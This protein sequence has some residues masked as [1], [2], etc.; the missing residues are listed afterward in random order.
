[1]DVDGINVADQR[2]DE[3]EVEF[4]LGALPS[5]WHNTQNVL[6]DLGYQR[7]AGND[8]NEDTDEQRGLRR[9]RTD[10]DEDH[11]QESNHTDNSRHSDLDEEKVCRMCLSS[12]A[13]LG[14]DGMSLGR[15]ISPCHCDG[16]MR[17]VHD[18]CLDQW[19][20]K[21]AA[22]EAARVCGQ[23]HA[24]YRFKRTPYSSLS[25]FVQ[26]SQMLRI[27][28]CVLVVFIASFVFGVL[29]FVSLRA[30]A[31][32]KDTP[33]AFIRDAALRPVSLEKLSWNIT[34]RQDEAVADVWMPADLVRRNRGSLAPLSVVDQ[35]L[36]EK[37][38]L[39]VF[40]RIRQQQ[41]HNP[42]YW[43]LVKR[44]LSTY[45][46][47]Y[48]GGMII[49]AKLES[50]EDVSAELERLSLGLPLFPLEDW[51]SDARPDAVHNSTTSFASNDLFKNSTSSGLQ[52]P[53]GLSPSLRERLVGADFKLGFNL[54]FLSSRT[55]Y[56][57]ESKEDDEVDVWQ[58]Q[59]LTIRFSYEEMPGKI[60]PDLN[61]S[62]MLR[63]IP[64]WLSFLRA[65]PYGIAIALIDRF[66]FVLS[67]FQPW[68][69]SI[70]RSSLQLALLLL[71]SHRELMWC[72]SKAAIAG[73]IAYIDVA[74]EPV[75]WNPDK[76]IVIGPLR[77]P[78]RRAAAVA[79]EVLVQAADSVFGPMWLN[80][81]GGYSLSVYMAPRQFMTTERVEMT[82]LAAVFAPAITLLV[83]V[84]VGGLAT[85]SERAASF[86]KTH[87]DRWTRA[88]WV[89]HDYS[90]SEGYLRLI[91]TLLGDD[92]ASQASRYDL[93]LETSG[94]RLLPGRTRPLRMAL[95]PKLNT[96]KTVMLLGCLVTTT[97]ALLAA[98]VAAWDTT[99]SHFARQAWRSVVC[100]LQ[101]ILHSG[102]TFRQ[103]WRQTRDLSLFIVRYSVGKVKA[104][105]RQLL[106]GVKNLLP[107]NRDVGASDSTST[108]GS[109]DTGSEADQAQPAQE[110][111][112][113]AQPAQAQAIPEP[114][115]NDPFLQGDNMGIFGAIFGHIASIYGCLHA[116][117]FA[118]RFILVY[119]PFEPFMILYALLQKL[120]QVDVAN[121][122]VLDRDGNV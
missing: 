103:M 26:A 8:D 110:Q 121:T 48:T 60:F 84:A 117:V 67:V 107:G 74:F 113:Q 33:L 94:S 98:T 45:R 55:K 23:C 14:D 80:W 52:T 108:R 105:S 29:A 36:Y 41:I 42:T 122:E 27:L 2:R 90:A 7:A 66:Y 62:F 11:A 10:I 63:I 28:L 17:Y 87:T 58:R 32:L 73:L 93:W 99:I 56:T 82:Q 40:S 37:A 106:R 12:E 75:R 5:I 53:Y 115:M 72:A 39:E 1:M 50:G 38:D 76:A 104:V 15:L 112:A 3:E 46:A 111:P 35:G 81:W 109:D 64:E 88:D 71:E 78:A 9:R 65:I 24:R 19:R 13:E 119:L 79:R 116:F 21:S 54:P 120:I 18:T 83:D 69:S 86:Q 89:H 43:K 4:I 44:P 22:T 16:S 102:D 100:I 68:W 61:D 30:V 47:N 114:L 101:L 59:N 31:A 118:M 95:L 77:T 92:E 85:F 49:R 25:A 70:A 91:A 97:I 20:R 57:S 51:Y 34:L 6:R 96:W